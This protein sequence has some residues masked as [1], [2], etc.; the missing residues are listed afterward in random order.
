MVVQVNVKLDRSLLDEVE[1]LVRKGY[2]KTKKEAFEK[3]LL[4]LI[5]MYKASELERRIDT[6]R[7]GTE[8]MP[9]VTQAVM[10]THE[11]EG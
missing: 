11:E 1:E 7:E 3:G 6:I 4:L 2:V 5:K 9:S 10:E 8:G